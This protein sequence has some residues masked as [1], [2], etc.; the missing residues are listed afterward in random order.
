MCLCVLWNEQEQG[1]CLVRIQGCLSHHRLWCLLE[2][3]SA[4]PGRPGAVAL[5]AEAIRPA[6][7]ELGRVLLGK[8]RQRLLQ[9]Q[10]WRTLELAWGRVQS[11]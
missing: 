3:Y 4:Q 10:W 9:G 1:C 7:G 8:G 2:S 6:W 5:I 11:V